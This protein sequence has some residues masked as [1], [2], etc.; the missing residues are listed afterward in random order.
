[1]NVAPEWTRI[2]K[3]D[4]SALDGVAGAPMFEI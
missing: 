1:M 3:V 2:K 4:F